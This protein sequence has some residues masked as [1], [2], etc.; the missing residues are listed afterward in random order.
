MKQRITMWAS[1]GFLV[2]LC[3]LLY[4]SL[5]IVPISAAE[6]IVYTLA[7]VTQPIVLASLYFHIGLRFYWVLLANA[8]TYA[9][10]GLIVETV[11]QAVR[12]SPLPGSPA[13]GNTACP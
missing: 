10:I 3:W 13:A 6:P 2:A 9:F 11:R 1:A 12:R 4:A 5:R 8:A 7:R